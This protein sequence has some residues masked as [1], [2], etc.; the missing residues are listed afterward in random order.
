[1]TGG[2]CDYL[3]QMYLVV[4]SNAAI[5]CLSD[6]LQSVTVRCGD[7]TVKHSC[8]FLST[9]LLQKNCD[10]SCHVTDSLQ[11]I[12][13]IPLEF[14]FCQDVK[15]ALSVYSTAAYPLT[16]TIDCTEG[17]NDNQLHVLAEVYQISSEPK[18]A[19]EHRGTEEKLITIPYSV[20]ESLK[21]NN[22]TIHFFQSYETPLTVQSFYIIVR[23]LQTQQIIESTCTGT[24][25]FDNYKWIVSPVTNQIAQLRY[26]KASNRFV[27][28]YDSRIW[29]HNFQLGCPNYLQPTGH[30]NVGRVQVDLQIDCNHIQIAVDLVFQVYQVSHWDKTDSVPKLRIHNILPSYVTP[31]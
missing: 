8:Q 24:I 26:K 6:F 22:N 14:W 16:V 13:C 21:P 11:Y 9:L 15:F 19:L 27:A 10:I 3:A 23:D 29:F 28:P 20:F 12:T 4:E 30:Q 25:Q 7:I 17:C 2:L 1:M 18:E 31:I 5:D